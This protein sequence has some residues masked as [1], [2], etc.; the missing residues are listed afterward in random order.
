MN[1]PKIDKDSAQKYLALEFMAACLLIVVNG[2]V[3]GHFPGPQAFLAVL[4]TFFL[5]SVLAYVPALA[6]AISLIGLAFII[7]LFVAPSPIKG[8]FLGQ[9]G[10]GRITNAAK[11]IQANGAPYAQGYSKA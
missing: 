3:Q 10:I 2:L 7:S 8:Q 6:T 1:V 5:L 11:N 4:V 9:L